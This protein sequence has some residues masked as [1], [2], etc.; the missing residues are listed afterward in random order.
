[1]SKTY[2]FK[3]EKVQVTV[4]SDFL[5]KCPDPESIDM[6]TLI[7]DFNLFDYLHNTEGPAFVGAMSSIK[8]WAVHGQVFDDEWQWKNYLFDKKLAKELKEDE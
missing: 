5:I 7:N 8:L 1:M 6:F 2:T 3:N 4:K